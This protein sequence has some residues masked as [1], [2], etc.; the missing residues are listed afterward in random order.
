MDED[1]FYYDFLEIKM[2][3]IFGWYILFFDYVFYEM[4]KIRGVEFISND[5]IKRNI[6]VVYEKVIY[7]IFEGLEKFESGNSMLVVLFYFFK[8][9]EMYSMS[10]VKVRVN[11]YECIKIDLEY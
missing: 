3:V 5:M 4:L 2:V 1:F 10:F 11:D 7:W 9:F 8:Y 6:I